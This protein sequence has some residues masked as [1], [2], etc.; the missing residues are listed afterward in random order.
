VEYS[1]LFLEKNDHVA[2]VNINRPESMNAINSRL[3]ADFSMA[4]DAIEADGTIRAMIVTGGDKVFAAGADIKEISCLEN[5]VDAHAFVKKIQTF[6]NRLASAEIPVIAAVSGLA[7]GGGCELALACDCRMASETARFALPEI[8]LGLMPGAGGTQRLP[9]LI[10]TARA[11]EM[12]FSGKP[13]S[14]KTAY[15]FGLV[16]KVVS[17]DRMMAEAWELAGFYARKPRVALRLIKDAMRCG[18]NMDLSSA[19]EYEA[20]CFEMLF[21]TEDQKEGVRAFMDKRKSNF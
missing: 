16:N 6:F 21:S 18:M 13:I 19:L 1:T 11:M 5:P 7:F 15:E 12:L 8:N 10:G 14:A 3:I 2:T 20:R 4:L 17:V 9:R